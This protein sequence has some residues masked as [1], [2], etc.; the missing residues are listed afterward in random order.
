MDPSTGVCAP[1][2]QLSGP[3]P[4]YADMGAFDSSSSTNTIV[5][6][7]FVPRRHAVEKFYR[8]CSS[9]RRA[10]KSYDEA[11]RYKPPLVLRTISTSLPFC[12]RAAPKL[13]ALCDPA[14][15]SPNALGYICVNPFRDPDI[16]QGTRREDPRRRISVSL[17]R[18]PSAGRWCSSLLGRFGR[19]RLAW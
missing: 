13:Q 17:P 3:T 10:Q 4:A 9:K 1:V 12:S 15:A 2:C 11:D 16:T 5:W 18:P 14:Q 6:P 19:C 8:V 7:T